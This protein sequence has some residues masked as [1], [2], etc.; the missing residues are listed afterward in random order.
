MINYGVIASAKLCTLQCF[1]CIQDI[2]YRQKL[3]Y[4]NFLHEVG[5]SWISEI[6]NRSES[7]SDELQLPENQTTPRGPKQDLPGRLSGNFR[8]FNIEKI[9]CVGEGKGSNLNYSVTY[10][11]HIRSEM[12]LDAFLNLQ[13]STLQRVL[14]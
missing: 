1:F 11:L 7:S 5:R 3:K 13:V 10:V 4:E 8:M 2:K 6:Q 12:K 14:L 9:V